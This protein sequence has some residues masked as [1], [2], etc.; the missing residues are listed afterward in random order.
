MTAESSSPLEPKIIKKLATAA[1]PSFVMLAGMQLDVFTPLKD[2]P[3]SAEQIAEAIGVKPA[4]LEPLLCA[5]V[6]AGLLTVERKFFFNTSEANH[7][8]IRN[9]PSYVGDHVWINPL[10]MWWGFSAAPKIA[11]SIRT[12]IPQYS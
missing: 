3:M 11:E 9:S 12:G 5:L 2:G 8:L 1:Y 7:F 10:I 6:A 4:K